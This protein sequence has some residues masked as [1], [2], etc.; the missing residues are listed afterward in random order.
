[1]SGI[2]EEIS[3]V[4]YKEVEDPSLSPQVISN[5]L[6]KI[7]N[8]GVCVSMKKISHLKKF[9]TRDDSPGFTSE[10]END[11]KTHRSIGSFLS[12]I[13]SIFFFGTLLAANAMPSPIEYGAMGVAVSSIIIGAGQGMKIQALRWEN[14][15]LYQ[16]VQELKG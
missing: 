2:Q 6:Y 7:S 9:L 16:T 13:G 8:T 14:Q 15:L 1:M 4:L 10:P 3:K 12:N 5:L 11:I